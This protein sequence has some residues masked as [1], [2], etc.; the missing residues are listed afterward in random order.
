VCVTASGDV[1][2]GGSGFGTS[3]STRRRSDTGR[4]DGFVAARRHHRHRAVDGESAAVVIPFAN[5]AVVGLACDSEAT[6][7]DVHGGRPDL[8]IDRQR[9]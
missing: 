6:D 9:S 2:I 5:D 1:I 8:P 3:R 4:N 7:R